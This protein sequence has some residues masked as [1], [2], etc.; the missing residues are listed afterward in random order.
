MLPQ[1]WALLAG[2][3]A[4]QAV[5]RTHCLPR[6]GPRCGPGSAGKPR[7]PMRGAPG[8]QLFVPECLPRDC[9]HSAGICALC[10][11]ETAMAVQKL[12][13][14]EGGTVRMASECAWVRGSCVSP[15]RQVG[16]HC[17]CCLGTRMPF[18]A[19]SCFLVA[20]AKEKM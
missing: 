9:F 17:W 19:G 15:G 3:A 12:P 13:A 11:T 7:C 14:E 10:R 6:C 5:C 18:P 20:K 4:S 16:A 8:F 2:P 1:L